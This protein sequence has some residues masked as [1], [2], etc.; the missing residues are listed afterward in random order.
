ME[1]IKEGMEE[2]GLAEFIPLHV[3]SETSGQL[4]LKKVRN[5]RE[6]AS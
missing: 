3:K 2:S 5:F 1:A 4:I 6:T